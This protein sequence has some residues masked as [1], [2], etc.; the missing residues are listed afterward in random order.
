MTIE[1]YIEILKLPY[2]YVTGIPMNVFKLS[3][4]LFIIEMQ[5]KCMISSKY[6]F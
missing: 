3:Y 5:R 2:F 1:I 6:S 4:T